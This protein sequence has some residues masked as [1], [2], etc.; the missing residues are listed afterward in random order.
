MTA[1]QPARKR[2]LQ[3]KAGDVLIFEEVLGPITGKPADAAPS[4]R[5][6][7]RLTKV[8]PGEDPLFK[9]PIVEIAWAAEDA[10]PF[11]FCISA[12]GGARD[13]RYVENISVA[14]GNVILVDHGKTVGEKDFGQV[15]TL[16]TEAVCECADHP[17]DIQTIPAQFRAKLAKVPLP[18]SE[19]L[20][21]DNPAK[22]QWTSASSLLR[23]R[24][25]AA[26][27]QVRLDSQPAGIW[28]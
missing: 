21:A 19:P 1:S 26:L 3:L 14:R 22:S 9:Q 15:P 7:V 2:K 6:A 13:C 25:R 23:Q 8:M 24:V 4:R 16:R 11:P 20:S 12:I 28:E 17:G 18:F 5:L 27:P 10:L